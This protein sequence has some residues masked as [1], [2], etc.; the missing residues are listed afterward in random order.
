MYTPETLRALLLDAGFARVEL[1]A[2][3]RMN[4]LCPEM[5]LIAHL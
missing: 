1:V 5:E 4:G 3:E 2:P